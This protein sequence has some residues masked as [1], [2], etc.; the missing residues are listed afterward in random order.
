MR[1]ISRKVVLGAENCANDFVVDEV[2]TVGGGQAQV[3]SFDETA[4]VFEVMG[5]N[6]LREFVGAK[7]FCRRDLGE[8]CF[9]VGLGAHLHRVSQSRKDWRWCQIPEIAME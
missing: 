6:L 2:S 5:E 8:L 1:R 9:L 7:A 4:I 3:Y